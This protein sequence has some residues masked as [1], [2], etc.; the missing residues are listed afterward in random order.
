MGGGGGPNTDT[1]AYVAIGSG[2]VPKAASGG[3]G[4]AVGGVW[5]LGLL[6]VGGGGRCWFG[7]GITMTIERG[8]WG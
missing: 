8:C 7:D 4:A 5:L 2:A 3:D 6:V 1:L